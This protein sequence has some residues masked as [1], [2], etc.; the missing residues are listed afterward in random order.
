[1][2]HTPHG[3]AE[4]FPEKAAKISVLKETDAHFAKLVAEYAEVNEKVH[5][6]ESRLD[7]L[8]EEEEEHLRKKRAHVKDHIWQHLK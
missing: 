2:S 8:S 4:E 6:A 3:L 7:L 1:M 5:R